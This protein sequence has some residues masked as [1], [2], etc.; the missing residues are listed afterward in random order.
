VQGKL[1]PKTYDTIIIGAGIAGCMAAYTLQAKGQKVL[2]VDRSVVPTS[3]GSGAAGLL[4][5]L[6]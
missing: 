6:R 3:G 4:S 2:L 1:M 5:L